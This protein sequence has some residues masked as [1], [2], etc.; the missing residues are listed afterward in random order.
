MSGS[1]NTQMDN[2]NFRILAKKR[3][4]QSFHTVA[5]DTMKGFCADWWVISPLKMKQVQSCKSDFEVWYFS[6]PTPSQFCQILLY[7]LQEKM[8]LSDS[9]SFS[10]FFFNVHWL[11]SVWIPLTVKGIIQAL[12]IY[13][14]LVIDNVI[15]F[16]DLFNRHQHFKNARQMSFYLTFLMHCCRSLTC[17]ADF[18]T[19]MWVCLQNRYVF[20]L[21]PLPQM[22]WEII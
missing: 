19:L 7:S 18:K 15:L 9:L 20:T 1:K 13:Y 14:Y 22:P 6:F 8:T 11:Q 3:I 10:F 5:P 17:L 2:P 4:F 16:H 21:P 12:L